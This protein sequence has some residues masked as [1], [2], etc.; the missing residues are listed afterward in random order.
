MRNDVRDLLPAFDALLF[1]SER[2][3]LSLAMLEAM[4]AGVPVLATPVGGTT[5]LLEADRTGI[6]VPVGRPD[7][8]AGQLVGLL[9]APARAEQ[10]RRAARERVEAQFS[11]RRTVEAHESL[12]ASC[13]APSRRKA[14]LRRDPWSHLFR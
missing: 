8:M 14:S 2:E 1:C 3:G 9:G 4:A 12:Y 10:I 7:A 6:L 13:L 11:L 5:E